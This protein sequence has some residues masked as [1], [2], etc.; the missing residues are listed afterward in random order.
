ML[1][2]YLPPNICSFI[3]SIHF[4]L[5]S[6]ELK[7]FKFTNSFSD[8]SNLLLIREILIFAITFFSSRIFIV[9]FFLQFPGVHWDSFLIWS[10]LLFLAYFPLTIWNNLVIYFDICSFNSLNEGILTSKSI[11]HILKHYKSIFIGCF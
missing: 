4:S 7:I 9:F 11:S 2:S 3:F 8:I 10:F 6:L 1:L 5:L